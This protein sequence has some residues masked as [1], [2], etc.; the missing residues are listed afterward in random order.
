MQGHQR[1]ITTLLDVVSMLQ[2]V[3]DGH[4]LK[5]DSLAA[6]V[7]RL[8]KVTDSDSALDVTRYQRT[9][10]SFGCKSQR[11]LRVARHVH[12]EFDSGSH[13]RSLPQE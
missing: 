6:I 13:S 9:G 7:A 11:L 1:I 2:R 12:H 10:S 8:R 5:E 3:L 4:G